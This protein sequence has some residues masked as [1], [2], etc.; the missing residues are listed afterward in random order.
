MATG[1]S[2]MTLRFR[3]RTGVVHGQTSPLI[4][5]EADFNDGELGAVLHDG[6]MMV[7]DAANLPIGGA[8][9]LAMILGGVAV[10]RLRAYR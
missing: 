4:I 1:G 8:A 10:T 2:L 6:S 9:L 5:D 7:Y 3:V